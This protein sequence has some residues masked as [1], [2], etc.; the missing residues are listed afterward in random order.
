MNF[1]SVPDNRFDLPY[2]NIFS[3]IM[4]APTQKPL[5]YYNSKI[6][7]RVYQGGFMGCFLDIDS[8]P[9]WARKIAKYE[10]D[11]FLKEAKYPKL[12][13]SRFTLYSG[14]GK[15]AV[16]W[17][18]S[19]TIN[20]VSHT[21]TQN[22]GNCVAASLGWEGF[23]QMMGVVLCVQQ[24]PIQ[25]KAPFGTALVY[26]SR[27]SASA[28]M[29]LSRAASIT[30]KD[31]SQMR[32]TYCDGKYDFRKEDDDEDYG[33][34]WGRSGVPE[35]LKEETRKNKVLGV[36][37][38]DGDKEEVLDILYSGATI[39]TGSTLTARDYGNPISKLDN[40]GGHA[41]Q[42]IGYDD[43]DE[44]KEYY[45][46]KIGDSLNEPVLIFGQSWGKWNNVENWPNHLWGKY[47][48]GA[49]VLRIDDGM[50]LIDSEAYIYYPDFEGFD[51]RPVDWSPV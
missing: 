10:S 7:R 43:T 40:I 29:T 19:M 21:G 5:R 46:E 38:F 6:I 15:R 49:F 3:T 48:E 47:P 33:D 27:G 25:W 45:K 8:S 13:D 32:T 51:S 39:Q 34:K 9:E 24:S 26:G 14:K 50:R 36:S 28:G 35:E 4:A 42:V 11:E 22:Y 12:S 30:D 31:G 16:P 2:V 17:N 44:F 1:N 37:R 23:N 20:P 18:F 41:Q